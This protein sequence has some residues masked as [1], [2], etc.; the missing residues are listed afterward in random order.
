M[1]ANLIARLLADSSLTAQL[2]NRITPISRVQSEALPAMTLMK[3]SPGRAYTFGGANGTSGTLVQF[4]IW[5]KTAEQA[6][7]VFTALLAVLETPAAVGATQFGMSFLQSERDG[8][9]EVPGVGI[10]IRKSADF[11]IWWHAA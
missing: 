7:A 10:I 6:K 5:A 2:G 3:V 8:H 4:D 1:E 11:L 9:E